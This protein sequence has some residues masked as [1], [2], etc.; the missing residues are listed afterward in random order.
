M[1][2]EPAGTVLAVSLLD[3]DVQFQTKVRGVDIFQTLTC[4]PFLYNLQI[5]NVDIKK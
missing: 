5:N 1:R 4:L 3:G 2:S